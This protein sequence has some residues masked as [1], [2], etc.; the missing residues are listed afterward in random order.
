M[1]KE[2]IIKKTEEYARNFLEKEGSG[3]DWWHVNRVWKMSK[4]IAKQEGGDLFV[5]ELASLLHDIADW[6]FHNGDEAFCSKLARKWL[7]SLDVK[8]FIISQV[9]YIIENISFKGEGVKSK[10]KTLEGKIVQDADRLDSIGAIGISRCFSYGGY[11]GRSIHDPNLKPIPNK[12]FEEYKTKDMTSINHFYEKLLLVKNMM[13]T[14]TAKSIAEG[15]HKFMENFLDRFFKEW[16][17]K[18]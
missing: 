9:C 6:K 17:G 15:R 11:K 8:E 3:H 10:I 13:N 18:L 14:K 5:I 2:Q 16:D 7:E 1:D 12:N 4:Y